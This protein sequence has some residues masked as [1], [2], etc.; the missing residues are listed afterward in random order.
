MTL[1]REDFATLGTWLRQTGRPAA[2][3]LEGGYHDDLPQLIDAFLSAWN[4]SA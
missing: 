1:E 3:V 4:Q 2:A